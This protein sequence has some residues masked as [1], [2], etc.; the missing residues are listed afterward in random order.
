M[1][2]VMYAPTRI[3][4]P[5]PV[6]A[7]ASAGTDSRLWCYGRGSYGAIRLRTGATSLLRS[8][9]RYLLSTYAAPITMHYMGFGATIGAGAP[10]FAAVYG[11]TAAVYGCTAA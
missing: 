3:V 5:I 4:I 7:Y 6:C 2:H 1:P 8:C 9:L 11:C 10:L